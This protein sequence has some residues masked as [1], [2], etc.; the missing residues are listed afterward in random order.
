[1]GFFDDLLGSASDVAF[2]EM[3]QRVGDPDFA[4]G[5]VREEVLTRNHFGASDPIRVS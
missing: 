5:E 2:N 1:M 3:V 4:Y